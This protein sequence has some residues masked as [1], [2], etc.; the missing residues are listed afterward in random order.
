MS[1]LRYVAAATVA[2]LA[3][4]GCSQEEVTGPSGEQ[5][6]SEPALSIEGGPPGAAALGRAIFFDDNLSLNRNQSCASC[7]AAE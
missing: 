7:H 6:P 3:V 2:L 5:I 1:A 4:I